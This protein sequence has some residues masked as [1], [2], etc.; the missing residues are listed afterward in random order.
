MP[1]APEI[2]AFFKGIDSPHIVH[3]HHN[4]KHEE[5]YFI[6][7]E[8]ESHIGEIVYWSRGIARFECGDITTGK[9]VNMVDP[10]QIVDESYRSTVLDFINRFGFS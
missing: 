10:Y 7:F 6:R 2:I 3:R 5:T 8:S 9:N 1:S 4:T